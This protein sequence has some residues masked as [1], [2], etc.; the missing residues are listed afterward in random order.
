MCELFTPLP[1]VVIYLY[2]NV[3]D[4]YSSTLTLLFIYIKEKHPFPI[5]FK[6]KA[7][8]NKLLSGFVSS[9]FFLSL[10]NT[11]MSS[12]FS[13]GKPN[14]SLE[15]PTIKFTKL[16]I[17]GQFVDSL[18]GSS[19]ILIY[20]FSFFLFIKLLLFFYNFSLCQFLLLLKLIIL[21][22]PLLL[23]CHY[24]VFL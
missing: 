9:F 18:S 24:G 7:Q 12:L 17:N 1:H 11:N 15:I 14:F 21:S 4:I 13:N 10:E 2:K 20:I 3:W 5:S 22:T 19:L 6:S 16:F 23:F 8:L